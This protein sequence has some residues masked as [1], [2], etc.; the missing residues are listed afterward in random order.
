MAREY[1]Q[2][3]P[4]HPLALHFLQGRIETRLSSY[5][6][7]QLDVKD[8]IQ[9]LQTHVDK[10][11]SFHLN[12]FSRS[13]ATCSGRYKNPSLTYRLCLRGTGNALNISLTSISAFERE[14]CTVTYRILEKQ[15]IFVLGQRLRTRSGGG[16]FVL[17]AAR[18][19]RHSARMCTARIAYRQK[20][21]LTQAQT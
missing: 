6:V 1:G 14:V 8:L 16:A 15:F 7:A 9:C 18:S 21:K 17:R 20:H 10:R 19:R 3:R 13:R 11:R 4:P 5:R 2:L 12:V